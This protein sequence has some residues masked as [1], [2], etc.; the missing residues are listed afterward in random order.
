MR[1]L[2]SAKM[3]RSA[4][5][6]A[7]DSLSRCRGHG[8]I[9]PAGAAVPAVKAGAQTTI[10]LAAAFAV[11]GYLKVRDSYR[12]QE[13]IAAVEQRAAKQRRAA[14]FAKTLQDARDRLEELQKELERLQR[15]YGPLQEIRPRLIE[16]G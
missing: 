7:H 1:D 6:G 10:G 12:Y 15:E 2:G 9:V 13:H 4:Q 14:E 3:T 5:E 11:L 16:N 8:R